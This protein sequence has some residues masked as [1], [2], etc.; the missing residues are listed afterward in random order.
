MADQKLTITAA[1]FEGTAGLTL[2]GE[3]D[4]KTAPDLKTAIEALITAGKTRIVLDFSNIGY[5]SS[6]GI[7][8]LN[9]TLGAARA[10]GG[11]MALACVSK[12]VRDTLDVMYFTKKI[13]VLSS[14]PEAV[15]ALKK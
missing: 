12:T 2:T 14:V 4:A 15:K 7:G 10:K 13:S 11:D 3:I 8:V 1:D 6:A 5:I 9:A